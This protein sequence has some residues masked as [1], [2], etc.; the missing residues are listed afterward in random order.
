MARNQEDRVVSLLG[1]RHRWGSQSVSCLECGASYPKP[2]GGGTL[3]TN[4][5]CPNCGS[6]GWIAITV[7]VGIGGMERPMEA[8]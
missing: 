1:A 6:V 3:H 8:S 7:L 2:T 5:G 4:P